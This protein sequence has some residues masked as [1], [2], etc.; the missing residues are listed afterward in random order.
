MR[1]DS[2]GMMARQL[3][4]QNAAL[5]TLGNKTIS[6]NWLIPQHVLY[7]FQD[8]IQ[9]SVFIVSSRPCSL[10]LLDP[11]SRP[12]SNPVCT[13]QDG[14]PFCV[15]LRYKISYQLSPLMSPAKARWP[16][17][18]LILSRVTAHACNCTQPNVGLLSC[19]RFFV[20]LVAVAMSC[21]NLLIF[22]SPLLTQQYQPQHRPFEQFWLLR[23]QCCVTGGDKRKQQPVFVTCYCS[24]LLL[25]SKLSF[26]QQ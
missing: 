5:V 17:T 6:Q 20:N 2:V 8:N 24:F 10:E 1:T 22:Q 11:L 3:R 23:W 15:A 19:C 7:T 26:W 18:D 21:I 4:S 16:L 9:T 25:P 14:I 13:V 12:S